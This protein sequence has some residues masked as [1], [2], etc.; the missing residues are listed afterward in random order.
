MTAQCFCDGVSRR[1]INLEQVNVLILDE[2][3]H[4]RKGHVFHQIMQLFEG[5]NMEGCRVIGLS[6]MLIGVNNSTT[7][8]NVGEEMRRLEAT[9]RSTIISVNNLDDQKNS[10][11][12]GTKPKE[13]FEQ[14]VRVPSSDCM[15]GIKNGLLKLIEQLTPI[16]L[17]NTVRLNPK[18][19]RETIPGN[20]KDIIL[21]Y[22]DTIYQ[23]DEMGEYGGYLT[24]LSVLIQFELMKRSSPSENYRNIVKS[25]ITSI[26]HFI[27]KMK[28]EL[29][30][31]IR[32]TETIRQHSSQK[33]QKLIEHLQHAFTNPNRDKDLQCLIFTKRRSTAK[34]LYHIIKYF[35][36]YSRKENVQDFPLKPDF[37]VGQNTELPGDIENIISKSFNRNAIEK[38]IKNETNCI[39]CTNVLEEGVDLQMCNLVIMYDLPDTFRS[40]KQSRGRARDQ[41]SNYVGF[42]EMDAKILAKFKKNMINWSMIG[43]E[44]K[45]QL[46]GKTIDREK[47][48]EEE[49]LEERKHVWEPF[50]TKNGSTLTASNSISFLNQYVQTI[51]TDKF[52]GCCGIDFRRID[53]SLKEISVGIK[54]PITSPLQHEIISD[55]MENVKLAKQHG[56]FK[57]VIELYKLGELTESLTAFNPME[58]I[59]LF[60]DDYF[61]RWTNYSEDTKNAGTKKNLR[62]HPIKTPDTLVNSSPVVKGFNYLYPI[63]VKPKF[64]S[65]EIDYIKAFEKL[66]G[67]GK[68]YGI[69]TS[70]KIPKLCKIKLFPTYGEV[71]CEIERSPLQ[72]SIESED[73]LKKLRKFQM[74]VFRDVLKAW[75]NFYVIDKTAFVIVPIDED[76]QIEWKLVD[77]FQTLSTSKAIN[78]NQVRNMT[79]KANDYLNKIV[80]PTYR[81]ANNYVV[82]EIDNG[83]SPLSAFPDSDGNMTYKDYFKKKY[84]LTL[85]DD[86]QFLI[87]V[88]AVTNNWNFLF[89]GKFKI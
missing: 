48:S 72:I 36:D 42:I 41:N 86:Q 2:C 58:K 38:F 71:E 1:F 32:T 15:I 75:K 88:K 22:K 83:Q 70:K 19:L 25:G 13:I 17:D 46:I 47:P 43:E 78:K 12:H 55:V 52:T 28:L 76:K 63:G 24:L 23:I 57:T 85:S 7:K 27:Q 9:L 74:T 34:A 64:K 4:A 10:D 49:I 51:P 26:E 11:F 69:L 59:E 30:I 31:D 39:A 65:N 82:F 84:D 87:E 5:R 33:V 67:N 54:L 37:V 62:L 89:P 56:A 21:L 81:E 8:E 6:G 18:T 79:F 35:G 44:M 77:N 68:S 3:H 20:I 66:I 80:T 40:Y 53:I 16:R 60:E 61:K 14:F 29:M 73:Q 45:Y 50:V